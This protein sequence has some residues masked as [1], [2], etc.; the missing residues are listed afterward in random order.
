[1]IRN[2]LF[3]AV[4]S[5]YFLAAP[6]MGSLTTALNLANS[7]KNDVQAGKALS[8]VQVDDVMN[9]VEDLSDADF[10]EFVQRCQGD[11]YSM[12]TKVLRIAHLCNDSVCDYS[13]VSTARQNLHFL[14]NLMLELGSWVKDMKDPLLRDFQLLVKVMDPFTHVLSELYQHTAG[15]WDLIDAALKKST[16]LKDY[17]DIEYTFSLEKKP[18]FTVYHIL[19][20]AAKHRVFQSKV[21]RSAKLKKLFKVFKRFNLSQSIGRV[22]ARRIVLLK[23]IIAEKEQLIRA[24]QTDMLADIV[25]IGDCGGTDV[26]VQIVSEQAKFQESKKNL[27]DEIKDTKASLRAMGKE[28]RKRNIVKKRI[29]KK[30]KKRR[31]KRR[32]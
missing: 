25:Q 12:L 16:A 30:H 26:E 15:D 23:S 14:S 3:L 22:R 20:K 13:S 1:M 31:A 17:L 11:L 6:L 19:Y 21:P 27:Q 24:L 10:S 8:Y 32:R 4:L 18:F 28:N 5:L 2:S 29:I 7:M 9:L